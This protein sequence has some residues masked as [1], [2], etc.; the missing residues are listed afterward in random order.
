M[1]SLHKYSYTL[2]EPIFVRFIYLTVRS[3]TLIH[4]L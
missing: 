3:Y 1:T 4:G 2:T